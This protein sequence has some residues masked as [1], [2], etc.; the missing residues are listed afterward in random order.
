VTE[1]ADFLRRLLV[2][3]D[4]ASIGHMIAGSFASTLH[5]LP[6]TTQDIDIVIDPTRDSL[7]AFV[8]SLSPAE[9]Y[10]SMD[11]ARDALAWR[12]MF[13]VI[14]MASAWKADL[15]IRKDR[16]FSVEE[17][18]R[19]MPARFWGVDV[20]VATPEDTIVAKLEWAKKSGGSE[21]Q[22]T[23]VAGIL[24]VRGD[25]LDRAYI[26]RWADELGVLDLWLRCA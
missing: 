5:G 19:R 14:D 1:V 6:R 26:Q 15:M 17:F 22:L 16:P 25:A 2:A 8:S 11:A 18:R 13:N 4:R 20:H 9:F 21:R 7:R 23:D 10:V 24:S 3:L 12:R